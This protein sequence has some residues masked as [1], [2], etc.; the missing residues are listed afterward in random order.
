MSVAL[1][2]SGTSFFY[3]QTGVPTNTNSFTICLWTK[4][5]AD[6]TGL[7]F[8]ASLRPNPITTGHDWIVNDPNN[9]AAYVQV[10]QAN[11]ATAQ[12]KSVDPIAL[13][14]WTFAAIVGNGANISLKYWD[15]DSI[16]TATVGQTAFTPTYLFVGAP[17]NTTNTYTYTGL[18]SHIRVWNS[19]L[20]DT[21]LIFE[22]NSAAVVKT[23][24]LLSAHSLGGGN[25]ATALTGE[26]G[27]AYLNG[28]AAT[29]STDAPT[30][31]TFTGVVIT[32]EADMPSVA[33]P[34]TL[35]TRYNW[36]LHSG[37]LTNEVWVK[38]TNQI[39]GGASAVPTG[40]GTS[41]R[42]LMATNIGGVYQVIQGAN[43]T[44]CIGY[45]IVKAV[46]TVG[47]VVKLT[48]STFSSAVR[49][50]F[51]L[52]SGT[53][54]SIDAYGGATSA[55]AFTRSI[56][57]GWFLVGATGL[58]ISGT[59]TL[60]FFPIETLG[61]PSPASGK[62][63]DFAHAQYEEGVFGTLP[64]I[65]TTVAAVRT[66]ASQALTLSSTSVFVNQSAF[67]IVTVYDDNGTPWDLG[68]TIT[69]ASSDP[70]KVQV[71]QTLFSTDGDGKLTVTLTGLAIGTSS[72]STSSTIGAPEP[73]PVVLTVGAGTGAR[74]L[75]IMVESGWEGT[76]GWWVGCYRKHPTERFP[77]E[78]LFVI[79]NQVF[80][81]TLFDGQSRMTVAIPAGVTVTPGEI[82][83]VVLENDSVGG[84]AV[85][86]PGLFPG[87]II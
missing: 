83:E 2:G 56:G 65:T 78:R 14:V 74:S 27:D 3:R 29:Y 16:V 72:I 54:Y 75:L 52:T 31:D 66:P 11:W 20:S 61:T 60:E 77:T 1:S 58:S 84:R 48:N 82:V 22:K 13:N 35:N 81:A 85:D 12:A 57:S 15:G 21:E 45:V 19:A 69:F 51:D 73:N 63:I 7:K 46:D 37:N 86:G 43:N 42:V 32:G 6:F 50:Q 47:V 18:F 55:Q 87:Q 80:D 36:I 40:F 53:I 10:M 76:A 26:T 34:T 62:S 17:T 8:L 4:R 28:G 33:P 68:G 44:R 71:T 64:K 49:V 79:Q 67:G 9:S 30:F 23:S 25:I 38:Q 39:V 24:G 59:P 70:S 41:Q 5:T